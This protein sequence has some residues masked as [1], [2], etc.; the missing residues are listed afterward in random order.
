MSDLC[1]CGSGKAFGRCCG[2]YL[3]AKKSAPTAEALMRSR[4]SAFCT[5]NI[6]YLLATHHH[7][8]SN[9]GDRSSLRQSIKATRWLNLLVVKTQK[10][11][12]KDKSG[13]VEFVAA[14]QA[15]S[16][17]NFLSAGQKAADKKST[18]SDGA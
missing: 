13:V 1:F 18:D 12:R 2:P 8:A 17:R 11:Q 10:G 16:A 9:R 14:Y 6:D 3:T 7:S 4:Y 5:G 15:L